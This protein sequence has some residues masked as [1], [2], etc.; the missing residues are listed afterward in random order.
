MQSGSSRCVR[1][2]SSC[3]GGG[4]RFCPFRKWG[5]GLLGLMNDVTRNPL[6]LKALNPHSARLPMGS[7]LP[8]PFSLLQ[9]DLTSQGRATVGAQKAT[10]RIETPKPQKAACKVQ[11]AYS[12]S[13]AI[14]F[15][16][17]SSRNPDG[18]CSRLKSAC[19]ICVNQF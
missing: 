17:K 4:L 19:R 18:S 8:R 16:T 2:S 9:E 15:F 10:G 14:R 12:S 3:L 13:A 5:S 6:T 7:A 1:A 11:V